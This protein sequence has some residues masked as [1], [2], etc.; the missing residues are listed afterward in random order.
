MALKGV[1]RPGYIQIRVTD[2]DKALA[3]CRIDVDGVGRNGNGS[4]RHQVMKS[5]AV[6][7]EGDQ[8]PFG[9]N[10]WQAA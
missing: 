10:L 6:V 5:A 2:L 4:R 1:L 9:G 7:G 3:A 8:Q